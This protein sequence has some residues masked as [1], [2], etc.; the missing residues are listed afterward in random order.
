M[1]D[2]DSPAG[3]TGG[4]GFD[5][6]R[7]VP[8][9]SFGLKL[10]LVC[11]L[12]AM[13]AIP[14]IF[15]WVL[16]YSRS[17]DAQQAIAEVVQLRGGPAMRYEDPDRPTPGSTNRNSEMMVEVT[18]KLPLPVLG[19]INFEYTGSAVPPITAAERERFK[20]NLK[21]ALPFSDSS[22]FHVGARWWTEEQTTTTPFVDRAQLYLGVQLK[23]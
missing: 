16:V 19:A 9:R 14:A 7:L 8:Q 13:M 11:V 2:S 22:Q 20:Q 3:P 10:M 4:G 6:A 5:F 1:S 17:N 21:F 12:A 23:R 18:T 15:V